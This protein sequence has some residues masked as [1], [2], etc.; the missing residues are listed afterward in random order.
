MLKQQHG[1]RQQDQTQ[2]STPL[3][4]AQQSTIGAREPM[5]SIGA[6]MTDFGTLGV[7]TGVVMT[8][9]HWM[10]YALPEGLSM[11]A[12]FGVGPV[13]IGGAAAIAGATAGG[14]LRL[15]R[16][17]ISPVM[18]V[19]CAAMA[20]NFVGSMLTLSAAG[21]FPA[22]VAVIEGQAAPLSLAVMLL[23]PVVVV[24]RWR[25]ERTLP[26]MILVGT[27]VGILIGVV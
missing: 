8:L 14:V 11:A 22:Q 6:W 1:H 16:G 24:L 18:G 10:L 27:L 21:L 20:A 15:L 9:T 4:E 3:H 5:G 13:L 7:V 17:S 23:I 2:S 19:L 12:F 25:T 26:W